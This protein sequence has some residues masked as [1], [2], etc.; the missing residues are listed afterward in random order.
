MS[1]SLKLTKVIDEVLQTFI[2][3]VA[4]EYKLDT[5]ELQSLWTG[6]SLSS[7]PVE[8]TPEKKSDSKS[9]VTEID[10]EILLKCNKAELVALCK[11]NGHKCSGTKTILIS[12][13]LGKEDNT[14][15]TPKE[16]SKPKAKSKAVKHAALAA[17]PIAQKLT[18]NIPNILIRRN[19]FNN[20]EHPESGMVFDNETKV[21]YGKQNDNGSV[22]P[23]T[24]DDID[25][26]NAFK[27]KFKIPIDLDSKSTLVDVKVDEL[28][29]E[30][31]LEIEEEEEEEEELNEDEL[32][33]ND[34]DVLG[35]DEEFE[36]YESDE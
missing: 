8:S 3:K 18:A 28:S 31:D 14:E 27:F 23:L 16:T 21:V 20:Y 22:D 17:T 25:Q 6:K 5:N 34:D 36:N 29:E 32:L 9:Q 30:E 2:L 1:F 4:T 10:P 15:N 7:K 24:D 35:D 13:L 19:K 26:C 33:E 12:R 11:S